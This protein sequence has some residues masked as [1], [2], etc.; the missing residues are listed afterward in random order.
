MILSGYRD[1]A[2]DRRDGEAAV[3][4][5]CW[6]WRSACIGAG[7]ATVV[8]AAAGPTDV[9]PRITDVVLGPPT[10]FLVELPAG[11]IPADVRGAAHRLAPAMEAVALR[12]EPRGHR[13]VSITLLC[14]DPL[15]GGFVERGLPLATV[16]EPGL[17]GRDE[18]GGPVRVDLAD[19]SSAHLV[20]QGSAGSG[21]STGVYG[22]LAQYA[23]APDVAVIGSDITGR[24]LRPWADRSSPGWHALGAKDLAAHI[25]V[26][27]RTVALMDERIN[28]MPPGVDHF[29]FSPSNPLLIFT[30]EE[31][32]GLMAQM[33]LHDPKMEKEARALLSR[34]MGESRKAAV[35]ALLIAQRADANIVG[36]FARD[37]A[38]HTISYRVGSL[39]ALAMLHQDADKAIAA[40]HSTSE[41]GIALLSGPGVPLR[42]FRSPR[43]TYAAYCSDVAYG[44][45]EAA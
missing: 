5:L 35:R 32:P 39:A 43:T 9:T 1:R 29:P 42:R 31:V 7:L 13:H 33:N 25:R 45:A 19:E 37:Q 38:S 2:R 12:I 14:E 6:A 36:G 3:D 10:V 30:M 16:R 44:S 15:R 18:D 20:V 28:A 27:R 24:T 22:F 21:K 34:I 4:A 26:L 17:W 11:T 41:P 8:Q 40:A 23:T